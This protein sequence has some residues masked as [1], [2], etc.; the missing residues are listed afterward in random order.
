VCAVLTR[1][2]ALALL[3]TLALAPA[4]LVDP[5]RVRGETVRRTATYEASVGILYDLLSFHAAGTVVETVDRAQGRYEVHVE[6]Q[7]TGIVN[8]TDSEGV[9][10]NGRWAPT[11][12]RSL[13][14]IYGRE[15]RLDI[16]YDHA[17]R[18]VDYRSRSETFFLRRLRVAEDVLRIPEG[19]H[20]DDVASATL[21]HAE[22]LWPPRP[23]G[24][25]ET[26]VVRR[27]RAPNEGSDD[28]ERAYRAELVPF[29]LRVTPDPTT[30]RPTALFDLSRF[31]SWAREDQPARIVFGSDRRPETITASMILGT[32]V[33]IRIRG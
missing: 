4:A 32:S 21:N 23:D 27:R 17:A 8:R 16:A 9:L 31:S 20:V 11:R 15:S 5:R 18:A 13:F 22:G 19:I 30:G 26:H 28:V 10:R 1:R 2:R 29:V 12:T 7:G 14:M 6:G 25:L 24:A 33:A 3:S